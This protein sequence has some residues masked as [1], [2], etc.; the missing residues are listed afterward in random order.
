MHAA[1]A[2]VSRHSAVAFM[3]RKYRKRGKAASLS[4][5]MPEGINACL[6][7]GY[8]FVYWA[9]LAASAVTAARLRWLLNIVNDCTMLPLALQTVLFIAS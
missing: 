8:A 5:L 7:I 6:F 1:S 2:K 9:S 3:L 4:V